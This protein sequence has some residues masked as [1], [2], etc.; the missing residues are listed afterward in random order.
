MMFSTLKCIFVQFLENS[1]EPAVR[2]PRVG[3]T[4]HLLGYE[5]P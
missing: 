4:A 1:K 2:E 5:K 3:A